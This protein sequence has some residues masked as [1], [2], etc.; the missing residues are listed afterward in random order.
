MSHK[1]KFNTSKKNKSK[2]RRILLEP[3]INEEWISASSTRNYL[4]KDPLLDWLNLYGKNK[5]FESDSNLLGSY[6]LSFDEYIMNQGIKFEEYIITIIKQKHPSDFKSVKLFK[7]YPSNTSDEQKYINQINE[8]YSYMRSGVRIIYQGMLFNPKNKTYGHPDLIIRSDYLNNI[9]TSSSSIESK[10]NI[11]EDE[12]RKE[13]EFVGCEFSD[14]WH[15]CIVDIKFTKLKLKV[16]NTNLLNYGSIPCYKGQLYIYNEAL[17]YIQNY[18]SNKVYIL[19]REWESS[20]DFSTDPLDKLAVIDYTNESILINETRGAIEW[21]KKVRKYGSGWNVFPKPSIS[22]LYPNMCNKSNNW[23]SAKNIIANKLK[24]ITCVWN[25]GVKNRVIAHKKGILK[26]DSRRSNAIN[27]GITGTKKSPLVDKILN[28][29]KFNGDKPYIINKNILRQYVDSLK[30]TIR[31]IS[32][33]VDFETISNINSIDKTDKNESIIFMIGI[34]YLNEK[35][36]WQY[37]SFTVK[38]IDIIEEKRIVLAFI[39]FIFRFNKDNKTIKIYHY[40]SAEPNNFNKA[41][42][43]YKDTI[44]NLSLSHL[45]SKIEWIDLFKIVKESSFVVKGCFNFS[46]KSIISALIE[47]KLIKMNDKQLDLKVTNGS[48][49]MMSAFIIDKEIKD[50]KEKNTCT[51]SKEFID[52]ELIKSVIKYNEIDCKMLLELKNLLIKLI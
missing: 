20:N 10:N 14:N 26:W 29:N 50:T 21:L 1:R 5:G 27:F 51:N 39:K 42:E 32:L 52:Y 7:D 16:N 9:I 6:N 48:E 23:T 8:T 3:E 25:C 37:E 18:N 33:F 19:G 24:E 2:K 43:K 49:A 36:R 47:Q 11:L 17:S 40:S 22:E 4:L 30:D 31:S 45:L 28:I 12:E 15:Y 38:E 41:I 35:D 44:F 34:G 13:K 46:L